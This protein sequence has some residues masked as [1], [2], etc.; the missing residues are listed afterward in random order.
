MPETTLSPPP[1]ET[2]DKQSSAHTVRLEP[3]RGFSRVLSPRELW[4][5]RDLAVQIAMR[6]VTLRYRQTALGAAWAILQPLAFMAIFSV[7]FGR[8]AGV[9]SDG[10]PYAL[11]ALC[12]LV[13]WAFFAST[14]QLG[15]ESLVMYTELVSK[16]YFPRI[17][18]P[19]GILCAGL[20]DL[21]VSICLLIVIVL[22][23][24]VVPTASILMVPVLVLIAAAAAL[25][26]TS[27]LSAVNV[28]FRDVRYV[29]PFAVQIW[30]FLTPIVYPNSLIG[31]P[32]QTLSAINPMVGV[33]EGFRWAMLGTSNPPLDL[34]GISALSAL[35]L[36][37][38]GLAYFDRV[39]R[40]FAD[41]I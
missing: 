16:I 12:A 13:P 28:R 35:V 8:L 23:Y 39:E 21:G 34:I 6:D 36:L 37:L 1:K 4:H 10:L 17:F 33:V 9:S 31:E 24:G 14:L 26:I 11:F 41:I 18:M 25:G 32:W 3:T 27:A 19:F 29:V 20:V 2:A 5:Y 30:L 38:A 22:V 15:S 40:T 7:F